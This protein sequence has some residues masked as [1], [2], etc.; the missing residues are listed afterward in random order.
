MS[1]SILFALFILF[2]FSIG[3][4]SQSIGVLLDVES[5]TPISNAHIVGKEG[6]IVSVSDE[7]GIFKAP[8]FQKFTAKHL[9][10]LD[11]SFVLQ[12]KLDTVYLKEEEYLVNT[13]TVTGYTDDAILKICKKTLTQI[14]KDTTTYSFLANRQEIYSVPE[15]YNTDVCVN[16]SSSTILGFVKPY[17]KLLNIKNIHYNSHINSLNWNSGNRNS[18]Y[19]KFK[20]LLLEL[21]NIT[22]FDISNIKNLGSVLR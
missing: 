1:K 4:N 12:R 19:L 21:F 9:R 18:N 5:K 10:F 8:L 13:Q 17:K 11:K 7:Y 3:A 16:K 22:Y 2:F 14:E 15:S 6:D 20:S